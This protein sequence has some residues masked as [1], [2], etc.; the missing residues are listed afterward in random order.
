MVKVTRAALRASKER[1][2]RGDG[3]QRGQDGATLLP[4]GRV[5]RWAADLCDRRLCCSSERISRIIVLLTPRRTAAG[6]RRATHG[7]FTTGCYG[8]E[9]FYIRTGTDYP[10]NRTEA[11]APTIWA[12]KLMALKGEMPRSFEQIEHK[13]DAYLAGFSRS[14]RTKADRSGRRTCRRTGGRRWICRTGRPNTPPTCFAK[15]SARLDGRGHVEYRRGQT[16]TGSAAWFVAYRRP[17]LSFSQPLDRLC[18]REV[19]LP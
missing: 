7:T 9:G 18:G 10:F 3:E 2:V 11:W 8:G 6:A 14:A 4:P 5:T 19:G 17:A 12:F 1:R 13:N 15:R 16:Q